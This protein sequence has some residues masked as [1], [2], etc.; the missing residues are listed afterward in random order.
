MTS[1]GPAHFNAAISTHQ[2]GDRK[3][4]SFQLYGCMMA[5]ALISCMEPLLTG[6]VCKSVSLGQFG[7][8]PGH[9]LHAPVILVIRLALPSNLTEEPSEQM[10]FQKASVTVSARI[11]CRY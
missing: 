4:V 10:A 1:S 5:V 6:P 7:G 11:V 9:P 8:S 3:P 2:P